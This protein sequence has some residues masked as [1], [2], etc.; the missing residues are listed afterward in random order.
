MVGV[1][2]I[3]AAP[4]SAGGTQVGFTL[5]AGP[6]QLDANGQVTDTRGTTGGWS[7]STYFLDDVQT[8]SVL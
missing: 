1:L 2:L 4:A 8:T 3:G 5:E 6:L 7:S